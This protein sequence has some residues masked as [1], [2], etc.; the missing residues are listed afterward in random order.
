MLRRRHRVRGAAEGPASCFGRRGGGRARRATRWR[1]MSVALSGGRAARVVVVELPGGI[2]V[3]VF[4]RRAG[5]RGWRSPT[6]TRPGTLLELVQNCGRVGGARVLP[7]LA[8]P[9]RGARAD[10]RVQGAPSG[11]IKL[12]G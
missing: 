3:D 6:P 5:W 12:I 7:A 1:E 9:G 10:A 8:E 4:A 11:R 2:A